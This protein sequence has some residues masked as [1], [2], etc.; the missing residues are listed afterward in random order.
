M[1][2]SLDRDKYLNDLLFNLNDSFEEDIDTPYSAFDMLPNIIAIKSSNMG[3]LVLI[4]VNSVGNCSVNIPKWTLDI[5]GLL[6]R[7]DEGI[8][9]TNNQWFV[10]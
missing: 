7:I 2:S 5:F 4:T 3:V 1:T 8:F 6:N 9:E 10:N